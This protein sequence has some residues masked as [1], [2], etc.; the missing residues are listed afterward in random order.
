MPNFDKLIFNK[1]NKSFNELT[2][3]EI[4]EKKKL[5]K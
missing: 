3:E 2:P 4:L 5:F 1:T